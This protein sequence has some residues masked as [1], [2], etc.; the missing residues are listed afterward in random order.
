MNIF[1]LMKRTIKK[2]NLTLFA[3][4]EQNNISL[5]TL[6]ASQYKGANTIRLQCYYLIAKNTD[7]SL[8]HI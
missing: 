3:A 7:L 4:C 5:T 2:I 8:W 1:S 6:L